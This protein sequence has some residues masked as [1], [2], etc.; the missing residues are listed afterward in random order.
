MRPIAKQFHSSILSRIKVMA[1]LD[2]AEKRVPQDGRSGCR[3]PGQ[4][5]RLPRLDHAERARRGRGHPHPGQGID[6]RAVHRTAPRHPRLSAGR[7][8]ALPQVHRRAV[9]DGPRHGS[10]RQ[11]QDDD[12][13]RGAVGDQVHRGQ[14]HHD[15]R[16]GRISAQGHHADPDQRKEGADVRARPAIDSRGTIR[17]RSWSARSATTKPRRSR[18]TPR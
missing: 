16:P 15:R 7:A 17:T 12:P 14:D 5:D 10:D 6:Q 2:I 11:R 13:V 1:E 18:S 8:E 9:R 4:N 3:M